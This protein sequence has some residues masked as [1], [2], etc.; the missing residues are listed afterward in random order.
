[1][2]ASANRMVFVPRANGPVV[3][4]AGLRAIAAPAGRHR[5]YGSGA[6]SQVSRSAL[7]NILLQEPADYAAA[8]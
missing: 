6:P 4:S 5:I 8:G 1:M 3:S 2:K 7:T